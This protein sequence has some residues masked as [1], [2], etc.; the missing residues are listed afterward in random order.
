MSGQKAF[1]KGDTPHTH[2]LKWATQVHFLYFG[3]LDI[4]PVYMVISLLALPDFMRSLP[5]AWGKYNLLPLLV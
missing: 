2:H 1:R 5:I 4:S 3:Y